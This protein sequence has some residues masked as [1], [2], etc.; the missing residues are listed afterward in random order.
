MRAQPS[1]VDHPH[2]RAERFGMRP[3]RTIG[4]QHCSAL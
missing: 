4:K 1:I 3:E 2:A